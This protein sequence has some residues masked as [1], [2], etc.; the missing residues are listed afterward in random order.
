MAHHVVELPGIV[1]P[2][3]FTNVRYCVTLMASAI[4]DTRG[5]IV[6]SDVASRRSI[7]QDVQ[8]VLR[9][10]LPTPDKAEKF[11]PHRDIADEDAVFAD[12]QPRCFCK[13]FQQAPH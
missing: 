4:P 9:Y 1:T 12:P 5:G 6:T 10:G 2:R 3:E 7:C 13:S 11:G 8:P